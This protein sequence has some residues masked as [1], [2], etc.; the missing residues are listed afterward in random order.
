M[1][2]STP[3]EPETSRREHDHRNCL[4]SSSEVNC[5][6]TNSFLI[7]VIVYPEFRQTY[8]VAQRLDQPPREVLRDQHMYADSEAFS[9]Q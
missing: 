8:R 2:R 4:V 7:P 3:D 1:S 6:I 5:I 9:A